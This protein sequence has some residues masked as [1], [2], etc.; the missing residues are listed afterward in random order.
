[1]TKPIHTIVA[2]MGPSGL[3]SALSLLINGHTVTLIDKRN[4][5]T[6]RQKV[7]IP[8]KLIQ[9]FLDIGVESDYLKKLIARNGL[10]SLRKFQDFQMS[11]LTSI[12]HDKKITLHGKS[13]PIKGKI[14]ALQGVDN[15]IIAAD[16]DNQTIT[17]KNKKVLKFDNIIDATGK[18]SHI[19]AMLTKSSNGKYK[20]DYADNLPQPGH[21]ANA[22][23][24]FNIN[25]NM[26]TH[27]RDVMVAPLNAKNDYNMADFKTKGWEH[28]TPPT[29]Y[30][31]AKSKKNS[32]YILAQIPEKMANVKDHKKV[33]DFIK[34]IL[35]KECV[36]NVDKLK[37][38][39]NNVILFSAFDVEH[40]IADKPYVQLGKKGVAIV[41]GDAYSPANFHF[42]HGV[43]K[44]IQDGLNLQQVLDK[45]GHFNSKALEARS[46]NIRNEISFYQRAYDRTHGY[47]YYSKLGKLAKLRFIANEI[48][49][50]ETLKLA[51]KATL[52]AAPLAYFLMPV[53]IML[54]LASFAYMKYVHFYANFTYSFARVK[55]SDS[56]QAEQNGKD[57]QAS[58]KGYIMSF[59][60]KTNYTK[61][62]DFVEGQVEMR[63]NIKL[64]LK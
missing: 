43:T 11:V 49:N 2:G 64:G 14:Q 32:I 38:E 50:V 21:K 58:W 46:K 9:D 33:I 8:N 44:G 13:V 29:Y 20:I 16:G 42:G 53:G 10:T 48:F 47:K 22:I 26:H 23:I 45:E 54:G 59:G 31:R 62:Y 34:P 18:H 15:E 12:C 36:V 5:Y 4:D 61:Y 7:I 17:L 57:A 56:K 1:M 55:A 39:K 25:S 28:D 51:F 30:I 3:S 6:L 41:V 19:M 60:Q 40:R 63:K 35:Q 24:M 27:I 37:I 52:I